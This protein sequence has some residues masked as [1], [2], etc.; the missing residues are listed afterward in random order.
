MK[1]NIESLY[2]NMKPAELASIAFG[3]ISEQDDS[4]WD[5]CTANVDNKTYVG[6]NHDF[7]HTI[8]NQVNFSILAGLQYYKYVLNTLSLIHKQRQEKQDMEHAG[9]DQKQVI[10]NSIKLFELSDDTGQKYQIVLALINSLCD[11]YGIDKKTYLNLAEINMTAK[12]LERLKMPNQDYWSESIK[13]YHDQIKFV[14]EATINPDMEKI[15][16]G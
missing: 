12:D 9:I 13:T 16:E 6:L 8:Q 5:A 3:S 15:N 1:T 2:K 11:R 7:T 14:F 4:T 10:E